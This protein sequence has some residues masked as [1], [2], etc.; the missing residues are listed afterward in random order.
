MTL[1]AALDADKLEKY[2]ERE[3]MS[4]C[5]IWTGTRTVWGYGLVYIGGG[6][7]RKAHRVVYELL[8]G[9]V[10]SELYMDH[11]CRNKACV[12]PAH[13]EPVTPREN[14]VRS[15]I[16]VAGINVRKAACPAGHLYAEHVRMINRKRHCRVCHRA[17][18]R[19]RYWRDK[20]IT[21]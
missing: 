21:A 8:R 7:T 15:E 6:R 19:R 9:I 20:E 16:S 13:L 18:A 3:P 4:G 14:V 5:W 1:R 10:P 12:N 11:L 17:D 2:I